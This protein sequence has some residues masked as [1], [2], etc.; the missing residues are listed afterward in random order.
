MHS[1]EEE[2]DR[3]EICLQNEELEEGCDVT[4]VDPDPDY[5]VGPAGWGVAGLRMNDGGLNGEDVFFD[6]ALNDDVRR[7][8]GEG[9][10]SVDGANAGTG[11][12][13]GVVDGRG[14]D[15]FDA[16]LP[17]VYDLGGGIPNPLY[18]DVDFLI[19]GVVAIATSRPFSFVALLGVVVRGEL[20]EVDVSKLLAH[21]IAS[22]AAFVL[23][24]LT[25]LCI[26]DR[27]YP[28]IHRQSWT[29]KA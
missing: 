2:E 23:A 1:G 21:A 12:E 14:V 17:P 3:D 25:A 20:K 27:F 6:G 13:Y 9:R 4:T 16:A 28:I 15:G 18:V 24:S 8:R 26:A 11:V 19:V 7:G 22:P 10:S 29:G 5:M